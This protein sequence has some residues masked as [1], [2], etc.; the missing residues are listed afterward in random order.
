MVKLSNFIIQL[1]CPL[2]AWAT[3]A[4][5]FDS[6]FRP[7]LA[8]SNGCVAAWTATSGAV[9]ATPCHDATNGWERW[10]HTNPAA[11]DAALDPDGDGVDNVEEFQNQCDPRC[12]DTDGD[13]LPDRL[14]IDGLAAGVPGLDPLERF[15]FP[16]DESDGGAWDGDPGAIP[17]SG[18]AADGFPAAVSVPWEDDGNADVRVTVSST[19]F[20]ELA[21]ED[22]ASIRRPANVG[23][24]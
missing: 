20:A 17:F 19:R 9:A 11:D 16:P 13:G 1:L 21:W 22:E 2:A 24:P 15:P 7:S 14:E 8:V 23:Y 6:S 18:V 4:W 3:T 5:Q 10:T 12:A